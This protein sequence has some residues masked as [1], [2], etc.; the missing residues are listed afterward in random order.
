MG[1]THSATPVGLFD[2][3]FGAVPAEPGWE[4][5]EGVIAMAVKELGVFQSSSVS[6]VRMEMDHGRG[7]G[8]A[9][10]QVHSLANCQ[11]TRDCSNNRRIIVTAW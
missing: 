4:G 2:C 7:D 10:N 9:R 6:Q 5:P 1:R 8:L 11:T 3:A